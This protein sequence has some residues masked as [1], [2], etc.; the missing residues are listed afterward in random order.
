MTGDTDLCSMDVKILNRLIELRPRAVP[1]ISLV[2]HGGLSCNSVRSACRRLE[3]FGLVKISVVP[4]KYHGVSATLLYEA[5]E[6]AALMPV[7]GRRHRAATGRED[8]IRT[9]LL[10]EL[11]RVGRPTTLREIRQAAGLSE[12]VASKAL[13]GLLAGGA[14][15]R[16]IGPAPAVGSVRPWLWALPP[17]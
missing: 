1:I 10:A 12:T 6:H 3:K 4:S 17:G 14:V 2:V 11:A 16:Q 15:T 9:G 8:A 7:P 5:A 13:L